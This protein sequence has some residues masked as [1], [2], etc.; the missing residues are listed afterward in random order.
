MNILALESSAGVAS[1]A[2]LKNNEMLGEIYANC[3][4]VHSRTLAPMVQKLLD[5][6]GFD[7]KNADVLAVSNG[8]GSFTGVRIGVSIVKGMALVLEKPALGV[9]SLFAMSQNA[10]VLDNALACTVIDARRNRFY[11][12]LFNI[13]NNRIT[14]VLNDSVVSAE[15][16]F[17]KL[18]DYEGRNI[19][20]LG[21]GANLFYNYIQSKNT[22]RLIA[23]VVDSRYRYQSA[24]GVAYAAREIILSNMC[25]LSSLDNLQIN[26]LRP[27]QAERELYASTKPDI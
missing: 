7:I 17:S 13:K 27:C 22:K 19:V 10:I 21:D 2:L 26:Y 12:A 4:L 6:T 14:R 11:A 23:K 20:I 24:K 5:I 25:T 1:V 18:C 8:P 15:D 16:L 9:S 3:G